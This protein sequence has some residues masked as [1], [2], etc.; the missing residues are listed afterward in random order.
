MADI[1]VITLGCS[2]NLVDAERL[3]GILRKDGYLVRHEPEPSLRPAP[4]VIINTCGFISDAKEE[5]VNTILEY[6]QLKEQGDV[7]S[8]IVMGCLS[9]R[10]AKELP[11]EIPDVDAWFGKFDI[12]AVSEFV[13]NSVKP[14]KRSLP[15]NPKWTEWGDSIRAVTT[16]PTNAY[17]KIAEGCDR[18]C[19]FCAIP[20]ITGRFHSRSVED[21]LLEV[22]SL[23]ARGF[24]E[25]NIIAQELTS[26]G[27]DLYGECRLAEL[28]ERISEIE[29]VRWIRLH[30]AYPNDFPMDLLPV[31]RNN[32]KVCKYLDI[33][34]QH[35]S[36][37]VLSNM[38]RH[39]TG[40]ETRCLLEKIRRE[41]PGIHLRTT[42]MVGFPGEGEKEFEE[43]LEFVRNARF[44]RMGA[45]AYCEEDDTYAAKHYADTISEVEKQ[46]RL[47]L[48]MA[49][50]EE[51][52]LEIQNAK[53]GERLLTVID[54]E[55]EDYFVGRT[56]FDSPEVDP[57]VLISKTDSRGRRLHL[58][59]GDY[60]TPVITAAYPF[61]LVAT[62]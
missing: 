30:Y 44:E 43:L 35:I 61:E 8:V 32:P 57:E 52:S 36:D 16:S 31:M 41:V 37:P 24:T 13:K 50:Q 11:Q 9:Q 45:F 39:I 47:N 27:K 7:R 38:R 20:L 33:A 29:G 15:R 26:Y 1:D 5:S 4:T 55:E 28:V 19:A 59:P 46:R 49:A 23:T 21:I 40:A 56:E 25:F 42:L 6:C 53:V 48:L 54:R 60:V 34:L 17:I 62:L 22:K 10:Y 14:K 2:K 3:M 58:R 12:E 18:F 51:I